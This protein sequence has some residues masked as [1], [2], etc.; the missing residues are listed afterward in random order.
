M[1]NRPLVSF[2]E[3]CVAQLWNYICLQV[4]LKRFHEREVRALYFLCFLRQ[5]RARERKLPEPEMSSE[6]LWESLLWNENYRI[7]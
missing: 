2:L 3:I 5:K 4:E 1:D 6:G 7:Y